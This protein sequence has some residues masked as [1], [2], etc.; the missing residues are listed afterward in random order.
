MVWPGVDGMVW[1]GMVLYGMVWYGM[2][3]WYG[4]V[5]Y[6][7]DVCMHGVHVYA[8]MRF[9]MYVF[10]PVSLAIHSTPSR[11]NEYDCVCFWCTIFV[12]MRIH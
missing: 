12:Y 1:N 8:R 3:L 6:D 4:M 11:R 10:H 2:V 9:V 7:M 5:W